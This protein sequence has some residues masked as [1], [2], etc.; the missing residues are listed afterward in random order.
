MW[1]DK[2]DS[3]L[4]TGYTTPTQRELVYT[5]LGLCSRSV[6]LFVVAV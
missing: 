5:L 6:N 4:Q 1:L 2:V 3:V